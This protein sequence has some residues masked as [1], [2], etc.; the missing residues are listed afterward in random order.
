MTFRCLQ[1]LLAGLLLLAF[2][3]PARA[4]DKA[5]KAVE[6]ELAKLKGPKTTPKAITDKALTDAFPKHSFCAVLYRQFPVAVAPPEKLK[7]SNVCVIDAD[8]KVTFLNNT[9]ALTKF[10]VENLAP[11]KTDDAAKTATKAWLRLVEEWVQDGFYSFDIPDSSLVSR[12]LGKGL[13]AAGKAVIKPE[14]GNMGELTAT[15]SFDEAGQLTKVDE[16]NK[17]VRGIRPR[18]QATKLL[19]ADPI[20]RAMAEQDI[21]VMGQKAKGYLDEQRAK[22]TPEVRRAIDRLWQQ[23]LDEGR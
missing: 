23:I 15:L 10:F 4:D 3:L 17:V 5:V 20:V 11:V 13:K 22:A 7:P 18:C 16:T 14:M 9:E 1:G 21:L 19:D 12:E 2:A 8:G 6:D